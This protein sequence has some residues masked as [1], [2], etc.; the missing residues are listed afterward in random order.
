[1][2]QYR[3]K[4]IVGALAPLLAGLAMAGCAALGGGLKEPPPTIYDLGPAPASAFAELTGRTSSQLLVPLPTT[5]DALAGNRVVVRD[6]NGTLSYFP[7]VT[8]SD[9][10]PSLVQSAL[11]RSLENSGRVKAVG[12]PGQSLAID[13]QLIVDVRA[14]ELDV[15]AGPVA[16][17]E[18]GVKLLDDRTGRIRTARVFD[19]R[20]PAASDSPRDGIAALDR[21]GGKAMAEIVGWAVGA[22]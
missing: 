13:D 14:F 15:T 5:S 10:L 4:S 6:R 22:L 1:M 9:Q 20:E 21:A 16:H 3:P 12:K 11:A 17:V 7:G 2:V 18:L 19:I 8:W